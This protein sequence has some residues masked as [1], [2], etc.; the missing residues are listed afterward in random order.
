FLEPSIT[1]YECETYGADCFTGQC[2]A[3]Y[4]LFERQRRLS[5][6]TMYVK[7]SCT[8]LPFIEYPD[9]R[10]S[11]ALNTCEQ[12][13]IVDVQYQVRVCNSGN[14]CNVACPEPDQQFV[15]CYQC[16]ADQDDCNTGSCQGRYCLFSRTQS[17]TGY[18]VK[19]SCINSEHLYYVTMCRYTLE[20]SCTNSDALFYVD[21]VQYTS[22]G[23]CE[24]R[25]VNSINYDLKL[26]NSS[27]YCNTVC[28]AG[29]FPS[30][31]SA[32]AS[33]YVEFVWTL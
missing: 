27:S 24:Y 12:R 31:L 26:C 8:N 23:N 21:N 14:N 17:S 3:Q 18:R 32:S 13:T 10:P 15:A 7:K 29:P 1:C 25:Q 4:C 20:K 2:T 22:F 30:Q 28:P 19:K 33:I 6:G 16:E 9:N 11:T 5:T